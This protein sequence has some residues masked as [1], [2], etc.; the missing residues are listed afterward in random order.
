MIKTEGERGGERQ[1]LNIS[2]GGE[3]RIQRGLGSQLTRRARGQPLREQFGQLE[4]LVR[5]LVSR[6]VADQQEA[7]KLGAS[8]RVDISEE[9]EGL[10]AKKRDTDGGTWII[11]VGPK[12]EMAERSL[13]RTWGPGPGDGQEGRRGSRFD[14]CSVV[15]VAVGYAHPLLVSW[16]P[17]LDPRELQRDEHWKEAKWRI[18]EDYNPGQTLMLTPLAKEGTGTGT[19]TWTRYLLPSFRPSVMDSLSWLLEAGTTLCFF[20]PSVSLLTRAGSCQAFVI[21]PCWITETVARYD[22]RFPGTLT[23]CVDDTTTARFPVLSCACRPT[24]S[25]AVSDYRVLRESTQCGPGAFFFGAIHTI[26]RK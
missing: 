23:I 1:F 25:L 2:P 16:D 14:R 8:K 10:N 19:N 17:R 21:S 20:S 6:C 22:T 12:S 18:G 13:S 11:G 24:D 5:P 4:H 9:R 15:D 26:I 7:V 3:D